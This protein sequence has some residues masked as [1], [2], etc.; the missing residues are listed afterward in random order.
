[1]NMKRC[2][3]VVTSYK[4]ELD[5]NE[6]HNI[7]RLFSLYYNKY[8]IVLIYPNNKSIKYYENNFKFSD[9]LLLD[10]KYFDTYPDGYN[11]L[12]LSSFFYKLFTKYKYILIHHPDSYII[13]DEL[14][15]W[16]SK[17][18]EYIGSPFL[19]DIF[20]NNISNVAELYLNNN[21]INKT[22]DM[23]GGLCLKK[24]SWFIKMTEKYETQL[25]ELSKKFKL[26]EDQIILMLNVLNVNLSKYN[27]PKFKD[28]VNFSWS[29]KPYLLAQI[30]NNELPFGIHAYNTLYK[31]FYEQ[32]DLTKKI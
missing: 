2:C 3:I 17:E 22:N 27:F 18:Y 24:V 26:N 15:Y 7:D 6:K 13:K 20:P 8:D 30:N 21:N 5:E 25:I 1:M 12:M 9:I 32:Y 31:Y 28:S 4:N 11:C 16:I 14:E 29:A 23:N 19:Y 10:Q